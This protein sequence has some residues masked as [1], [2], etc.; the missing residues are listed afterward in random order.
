MYYN[1]QPFLI[2][3]GKLYYTRDS[4][5][6]LRYTFWPTRSDYHN[7]PNINGVEQAP[8]DKFRA[9]HT[10]LVADDKKAEFKLDLAGAYPEAAA[11]VEWN[12]TLRL[13]RGKYFLLQDNYLL[14]EYKSASYLNFLT[15]CE[16]S[17]KEAGVVELR[18]GKNAIQLEY[19][20]ASLEMIIEPFEVND[21]TVE[22]SWG[23]TLT[24]LR[25]KI[26]SKKLENSLELK[27]TGV[28]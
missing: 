12:R 18:N 6:D 23:K 13:E 15:V 21:S 3:A 1:N 24:R 5:G 28:K 14:S 8:G 26:L 20:T 11:V 2:D 17:E 25:F 10:G 16:V 22:I 27:V 7:V 9:K 4:F 19:N